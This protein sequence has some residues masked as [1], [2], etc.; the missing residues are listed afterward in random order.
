MWAAPAKSLSGLWLH[1]S[2]TVNALDYFTSEVTDML[3]PED[4]S[5]EPPDIRNSQRA[6]WGLIKEIRDNLGVDLLTDRAR[7]MFGGRPST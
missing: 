6:Y 3:A 7:G 2:Q 1:A 4:K 5:Q